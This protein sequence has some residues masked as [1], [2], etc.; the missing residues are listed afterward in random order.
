MIDGITILNS[1]EVVSKTQFNWAA[2]LVGALIGLV[3]S[4]VIGFFNSDN[5]SE[6]FLFFSIL[7]VL[8]ASIGFIFGV[9]VSATPAEYKSQYEV[10]ISDEVSMNDFYNRYEII[11]QRGEIYV[12]KEKEGEK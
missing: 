10:T 12:I 11:E 5:L 1:Y 9:D 2:F 8:S 6:F 4:V 7:G 3:I